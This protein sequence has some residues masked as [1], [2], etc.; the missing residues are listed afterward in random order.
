MSNEGK[1]EYPKRGRG[2][3]GGPMGGGMGPVEKAKDF[4]GSI[5]KLAKY[6]GKYKFKILLVVLFTIGSTVFSI[7]GPKLSGNVTTDIFTGLMEKISGTGEIDFDKIGRSLL[8]ILLLYAVSAIFSLIQ[9]FIMTGV[10][11]KVTYQLRKE[12]SQKINR[13]PM[14]YFETKT[15]G[16]VLS[17]VTNDVDTL[18]QNLTQSITQI[19]SSIAM[20]IG[21]LIMMISISGT[22]TI[23]AVLTLPLS[24]GLIGGIM[25]KSQKYFKANRNIWVM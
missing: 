20:V 14:N 18:S 24:M 10:S 6:I 21:I 1:K 4:K 9:G 12:I 8:F 2:P 11:Q 22:M 5:S 15:H 16:E 19:I 23:I 13:M 25:K 3:M 7:V 17:R